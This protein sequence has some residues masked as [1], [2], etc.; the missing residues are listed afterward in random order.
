MSEVL[1][2]LKE[3]I[4]NF[5]TILRLSRYEEKATY[6]SHYLGLLWQVLNPI[7][8]V[9]I[10]YLVFGVGINGGRKIADIPYLPW[11]L[12]GIIA[13]FFINRSLMSASNSIYK[14]VNLVARMKFPVSILPSNSIVGHLS[15]YFT[16]MIFL[17]GVYTYY[18]IQPSLYWLQ[19]LY[20]FPAMLV[21]L[22]AVGLFNATMTTLIR[23][24]YIV[25]QSVMRL[26]FYVSGPIWNIQNRNLPPTLVKFLK[27][28]PI[29]YLIEG[30]R[31]T[32][33][34]R[35]WFWEKNTYGLIFWGITLIILIV[36]SHLHLKFRSKFVELV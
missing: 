9:A 19:Y 13:W 33:T 10:Y 18:G 8:Q 7:I 2:I 34:S 16:M 26:A 24:Y 3:Q 4:S 1:V 22:F 14:Q 5:R 32:F 29:Y 36:G 11:M 27:L 21:F 20:Y 25:F 12:T 35:Q 17:M 31:D 30:F 6:Q 15:S 28:N 23:D